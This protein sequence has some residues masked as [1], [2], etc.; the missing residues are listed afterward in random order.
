MHGV[1]RVRSLDHFWARRPAARAGSAAAS[2]ASIAAAATQ[3]DGSSPVG[4]SG[5]ASDT[6]RAVRSAVQWCTL[7]GLPPHALHSPTR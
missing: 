2:A 5:R 1:C 7:R 4:S 3:I 6:R